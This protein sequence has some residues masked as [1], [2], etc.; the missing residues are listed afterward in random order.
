[1]H[2]REKWGKTFSAERLAIAAYLSTGFSKKTE[3]ECSP[4]LP[5]EF[6]VAAIAKGNR[7]KQ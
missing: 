4:L 6:L 1:L 3:V 2:Q 5:I 7:K